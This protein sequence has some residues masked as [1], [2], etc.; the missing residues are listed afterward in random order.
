MESQDIEKRPQTSTPGVS[1]EMV[2]D[3]EKDKKQQKPEKKE[4]TPKKK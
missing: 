3:P 4:E 1:R 2:L